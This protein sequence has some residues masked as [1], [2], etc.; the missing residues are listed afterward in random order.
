MLINIIIVTYSWATPAQ[1]LKVQRYKPGGT[2]VDTEYRLNV[3][4]RNVQVNL[5]YCI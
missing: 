1:Q 2:V 3:Y 4:E 5:F